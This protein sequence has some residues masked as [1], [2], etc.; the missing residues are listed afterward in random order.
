MDLT[1]NLRVDN[2]FFFFFL[3]GGSKPF[4][5]TKHFFGTMICCVLKAFLGQNNFW[6][7]TVLGQ[8]LFF[9]QNLFFYGMKNFFQVTK[10]FRVKNYFGSRT[11]LG[12]KLFLGQ[13]HFWGQNLFSGQTLFWQNYLYICTEFPPMTTLTYL[14]ALLLYLERKK[15]KGTDG[16]PYGVTESLL[17][18]LIAAK[19]QSDKYLLRKKVRNNCKFEKTFSQKK[20]A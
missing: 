3:G 13:S 4:G 16:R 7:K 19:N 6:V 20:L 18:L 11:F 8:E 14:I 12:Q 15:N 1:H 9:G 2:F 5:G 17:E 10:K